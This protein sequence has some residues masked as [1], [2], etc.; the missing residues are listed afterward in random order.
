MNDRHDEQSRPEGHSL[1][2]DIAQIGTLLDQLGHADRASAPASIE[3][4][5]MASVQ[6]VSAEAQQVEATERSL[7]KLGSEERNSAPA[8]FEDRIFL[9]THGLLLKYRTEKPE[10]DRQPIVIRRIGWRSAGAWAMRA[11]AGLALGGGVIWGYRAMVGTP[12]PNK[13]DIALDVPGGKVKEL[14]NAIETHMDDLSTVLLL[15]SLTDSEQDEGATS[16]TEGDESA[17]WL[18]VYFQIESEGSL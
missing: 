1:P 18:Q 11:A 4:R 14:E 16:S 7:A 5:V 8:T 3:S 10:E 2:A 15:A 6:A 12:V 17:D 9:A 13:G